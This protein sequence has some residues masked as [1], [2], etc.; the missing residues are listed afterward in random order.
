MG[1]LSGR[2]T[3]ERFWVSGP[4]PRQFGPEQVEI[5]ERFAIGRTE[6]ALPE[7]PRVGFLAGE[8]LLDLN[9]HLEKNVVNEALH[10]AVRIDTDQIPAAVRRAWLQM[11]LAALTADNPSGRPT[12]AQRQEA[13]EAV[14]AR[15]AEEAQSGK[16]RKMQQFPVLWDARH[17]VFYFGGSSASAVELCKDLFASAFELELDRIT[18]GKLAQAWAAERKQR[19]AL[20][21]VA[22][23][24]FHDVNPQAEILWWNGHSENYD[25]LGNEFLLWLWWRWET[26]SDTLALP[27]GSEVTGMLARTLSLECPRGESGKETISAESPVHLPEARQ[28]I[29]TGKLPRKAGLT[30]VRHGEQ[31]D[32]T[33]QAETFSVGGA[34]IQTG[35]E[36]EGRAAA[37]DRIDSVRNLSETLDLLFQA[38]CERRIGKRWSGELEQMRGWLESKLNAAQKPAA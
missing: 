37:E 33:L 29:Q 18:S 9:F 6:A 13:K 24:V 11:E 10:G 5:L 25:Y 2:V 23:S 22:P 27:D 16:F 28:A 21:E 35:E 3:F 31:Y 14:E 12:K 30:L 8:H 38:F 1:F 20:E 26:D 17:G 7:Q 15:C 34:R 4:A 19:R 32:L 36:S